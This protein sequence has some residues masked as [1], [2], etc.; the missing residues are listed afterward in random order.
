MTNQINVDTVQIETKYIEYRSC[1]F[2]LPFF[3]LE[4]IVYIVRSAPSRHREIVDVVRSVDP[5]P[6]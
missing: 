6:T 1:L 2:Y 4:L 5:E 3:K